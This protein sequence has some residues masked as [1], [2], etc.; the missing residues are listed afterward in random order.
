[1][2]QRCAITGQLNLAKKIPISILQ[3]ILMLVA[4][5]AIIIILVEPSEVGLMQGQGL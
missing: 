4:I 5:T 2:I 1:M 3:D